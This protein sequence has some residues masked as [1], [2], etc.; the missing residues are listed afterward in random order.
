M[1]FESV[2]GDNKENIVERRE[3]LKES[4]GI[5]F[6]AKE[7]TGRQVSIAEQ[8]KAAEEIDPP[9]VQFD[10]RGKTDEEI[11]DS[12]D[13]LISYRD[14]HPDTKISIHG[15]NPV[16]DTSDLGL[17][18]KDR[19]IRELD[20]LQEF[21]GSYT[22][23]PPSIRSDVFEGL[24]RAQK[25]DIIDGYSAVLAHTV[26]KAIENEKEFSIAIENMPAEGSEGSWG[27]NLEDITILIEGIRKNLVAQGVDPD[28]AER[29]IGVTLDINHALE[30]TE[31]ASEYENILKPWFQKLGE[32]L[33][34]IHVYA[35]SK[36]SQKFVSRYEMALDLASKFSPR[37][38]LFIESK[39][40]LDITKQIYQT[41]KKIQ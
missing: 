21:E 32:H 6:C 30:K 12:L 17:K 33:R 34:V 18:N 31:E 41:A 37:A 5:V 20:I 22:V 28:V 15:D 3:E 1:R 13:D 27:Q 9:S 19:I 4:L 40:G 29:Y 24:S 10:L 25:N 23:H 8:I 14:T 39:H 2:S 26:K 35:P 36:V 38:R 16:I 11:R 7:K